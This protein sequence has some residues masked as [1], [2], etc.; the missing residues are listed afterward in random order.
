MRFRGF[1]SATHSGLFEPLGAHT[2][3]GAKQLVFV[4]DVEAYF[5]EMVICLSSCSPKC[6]FS[7]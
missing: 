4:P 5:H 2:L 6:C 7:A 1:P 3:A